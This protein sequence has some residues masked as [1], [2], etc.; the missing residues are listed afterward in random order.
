MR[1]QRLKDRTLW[2]AASNEEE[3]DK[4]II[5]AGTWSATYDRRRTPEEY[6]RMVMEKPEPDGEAE[7]ISLGHR[8]GLLKHPCSIDYKC[9]RCGHEQYTIGIIPDICPNCHAK[10][11]VR[12][13]E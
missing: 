6:L 3:V 12:E 9:S 2:I 11:K 5:S 13:E 4:I 10:M 8:M 7:W 1:I